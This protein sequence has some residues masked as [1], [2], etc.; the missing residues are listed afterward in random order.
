MQVAVSQLEN[1][2]ETSDT[3]VKSEDLLCLPDL[4][5]QEPYPIVSMRLPLLQW[6]IVIGPPSDRGIRKP[7]E[8]SF[9]ALRSRTILL[10]KDSGESDLD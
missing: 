4:R 5:Y 8:V 7:D 1:S 3:G 2:H 10:L 6:H 9:R